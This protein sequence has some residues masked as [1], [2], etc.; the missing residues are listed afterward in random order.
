MRLQI[1][2]M[3]W[4][5]KWKDQKTQGPTDPKTR[6]PKGQKT[7]RL[8]DPKDQKTQRPKDPK[9]ELRVLASRLEGICGNLG[10]RIR[11]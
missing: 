6:R 1:V 5:I 9:A 3:Q 2:T 11:V 10:F 8:K 4:E 7:Q